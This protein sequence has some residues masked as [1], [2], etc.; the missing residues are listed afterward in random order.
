MFTD[1]REFTEYS[2]INF[3]INLTLDSVGKRESTSSYLH[4]LKKFNMSI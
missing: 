1:E 2:E 3:N 4:K